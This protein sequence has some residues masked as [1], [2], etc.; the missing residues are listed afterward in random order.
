MP[1][2]APIWSMLQCLY[3]AQTACTKALGPENKLTEGAGVVHIALATTHFF[4]QR[5]RAWG[6]PMTENSLSFCVSMWRQCGL[7]I[8]AR[9]EVPTTCCVLLGKSNHP[10]LLRSWCLKFSL[11]Y[12]T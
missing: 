9:K 5:I 8:R 7:C 4:T 2:L 10:S 11:R 12:F 1:R 3:L 6:A